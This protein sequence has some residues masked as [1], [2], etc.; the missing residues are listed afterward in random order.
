M[1][2]VY[3]FALNLK[4]QVTRQQPPG[5]ENLDHEQQKPFSWKAS[6]I[7]AAPTEYCLFRQTLHWQTW[8]W[9][10]QMSSLCETTSKGVFLWIQK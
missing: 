9:E 4:E 7:I 5:R 10:L 3:V 6:H 8:W 2:T 1:G